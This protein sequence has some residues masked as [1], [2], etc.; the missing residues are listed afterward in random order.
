[1]HAPSLL[2]VASLPSFACNYYEVNNYCAVYIL[3]FS[4]HNSKGFTQFCRVYMWVLCPALNHINHTYIN[5]PVANMPVMLKEG[6]T[7]SYP[8]IIVQ[9]TEYL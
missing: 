7:F 6:L 5:T 2:T 8:I 1:M 3:H 4:K 9:F